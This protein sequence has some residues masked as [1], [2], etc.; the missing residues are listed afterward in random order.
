MTDRARRR[1]RP[2]RPQRL[3]APVAFPRGPQLYQQPEGYP[4]RIGGPG[5]KPEDFPGSGAEW[6]IYWACWP[7]LGLPGSARDTAPDYRGF[8]DAFAFQ[9]PFE[10]GR[11]GGPGGQ[12]FDFVF[13]PSRFGPGR[14]VRVQTE[15]W[16]YQAGNTKQ[17]TDALLLTRAAKFYPVTDIFDFD[18][19]GDETGAAAVK[20]LKRALAG[21]IFLNPIT[22]GVTRRG[23]YS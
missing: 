7:A 6:P 23:G 19:M 14:I 21:E 4:K 1:R 5:D 3:A 16:H 17:V 12:V 13:Y 20:T 18:Y 2:Q 11:I 9:D 15:Q 10:G 22:A 8:P